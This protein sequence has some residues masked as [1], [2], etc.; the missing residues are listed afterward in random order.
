MPKVGRPNRLEA[1]LILERLA[2]FPEGLPLSLI[3]PE[4]DMPLSACHRL[5]ADLQRRGYVRQIRRQGDYL[6]TIKVASL[7]LGFL[8][9]A[10]IATGHGPRQCS[11]RDAGRFPVS[12][13]F[14]KAA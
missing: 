12:K 5:L 1:L 8:S 14:L 2:R 6:L 10:G 13:D 11:F 3:A 4:L 7:G 9:S